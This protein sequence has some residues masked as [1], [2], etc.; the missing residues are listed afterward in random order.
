MYTKNGTG[1][2]PSK[3]QLRTRTIEQKNLQG[4][5][6]LLIK[7]QWEYNDSILH[8]ASSVCEAATMKPISH[9]LWWSGTPVVQID[10]ETRQMKLNNVSSPAVDTTH[11]GNAIWTVVNTFA[12]H[13]I[14]HSHVD[15]ELFPPLAL[16]RGL[17]VIIPFYDPQ[18]G[19]LLEEEVY[20]VT[21]ENRLSGYDMQQIDC[22][23]IRKTT[24]GISKLYWISKKTNEVIMTEQQVDETV[25]S[26]TL[27]LGFGL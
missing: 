4:R 10:Y 21:G 6:V 27:K 24:P 15:L 22:W 8:T 18:T 20:T 2:S 23:L 26:Y 17:T 13:Y 12:N 25:R 3:I 5:S 14:L 11:S 19:T 9:E 16:T 7:D 1:A